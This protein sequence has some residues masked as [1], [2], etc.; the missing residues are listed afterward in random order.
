MLQRMGFTV[1]TA[2]S[3]KEAL[4]TLEE[5]KDKIDIVILDIIMPGLDGEKTYDLLKGINPGLKVLLSSGYSMIEKA[6]ELMK[7]GCDGFIQKPFGMN[8]LSMELNKIL[9]KK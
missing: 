6:E 9:E 1:L 7:K 2:M 3:G 5:N 8:D 4:Q